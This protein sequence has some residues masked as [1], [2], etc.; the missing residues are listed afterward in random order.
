MA[1][2][3]L[4]IVPL[5]NYQENKRVLSKFETIKSDKDNP[6]EDAKNQEYKKQVLWDW[7]TWLIKRYLH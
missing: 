2:I 1:I 4:F 6:D 5:Y 3:F 7:F